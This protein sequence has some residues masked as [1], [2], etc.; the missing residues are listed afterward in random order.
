[1]ERLDRLLRTAIATRRLVS[2]T[3]D[4]Y[5]RIAEPHDYGIIRGVSRLFFYQLGGG[6][7]SGKPLGWRLGDL[8]RMS[9]V[10]IL[11][12][13]FEGPRPAP[14]GRHI[15]WDVLIATVS[16]RPVARSRPGSSG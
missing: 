15:Q 13:R 8:S 7:R 14:S 10:R 6:S 3:L 4:G 12:D 16:P 2:F 5:Q 11:D 1:M 9:N